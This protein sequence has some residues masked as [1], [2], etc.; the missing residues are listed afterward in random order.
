LY[1]DGAIP[2]VPSDPSTKVYPS[3]AAAAANAEPMVP[4]APARLSTTIG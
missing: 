4:P 1:N 2:M 3:G